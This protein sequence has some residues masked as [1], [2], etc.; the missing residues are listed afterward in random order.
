MQTNL[1][2]GLPAVGMAVRNQDDTGSR[3]NNTIMFKCY[4]ATIILKCMNS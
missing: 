2:V 3:E 1:R 4:D